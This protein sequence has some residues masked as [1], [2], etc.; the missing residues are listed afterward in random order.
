MHLQ[1]AFGMQ[2]LAPK[3]AG[4]ERNLYLI[5]QVTS[6]ALNPRSTANHH[7][8]QRHRTSR[9]L[10]PLRAMKSELELAMNQEHHGIGCFTSSRPPD[11]AAQLVEQGSIMSGE[12][13]KVLLRCLW[14]HPALS[15]RLQYLSAGGRQHEG[16]TLAS[17]PHCELFPR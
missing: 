15:N 2:G 6:S 5:R 12:E 14:V 10:V 11:N 9:Q 16:T 17:N 13:I 4:Q 7:C 8:A 3:E 1:P